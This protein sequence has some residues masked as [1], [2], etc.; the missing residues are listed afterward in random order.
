MLPFFAQAPLTRTAGQRRASLSSSR[1][2]EAVIIPP[3]LTAPG[4]GPDMQQPMHAYKDLAKTA[5]D[6]YVELAITNM[7]IGEK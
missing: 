2:R 3:Q 7:G 6:L 1:G 5:K 4:F